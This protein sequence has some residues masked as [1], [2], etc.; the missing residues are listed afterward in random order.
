MDIIGYIGCVLLHGSTWCQMIKTLRRKQVD[1]ISLV[2]WLCVISGLVLYLI[3][4]I[5]IHVTVYI[6]A[7]C[8]GL[9]SS[10]LYLTLYFIYKR[11]M[12]K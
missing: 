12:I 10:F 5:Q 9:L 6:V 7:N 1:D 3:Y 8:F 2:Y 4:S 11:R